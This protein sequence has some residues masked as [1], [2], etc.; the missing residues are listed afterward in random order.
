VDILEDNMFV[1]YVNLKKNEETFR[2]SKSFLQYSLLLKV[3]LNLLIAIIQAVLIVRVLSK[4][5]QKYSN[6]I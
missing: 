6:M 1:S 4:Y 2:K 3:I 5:R